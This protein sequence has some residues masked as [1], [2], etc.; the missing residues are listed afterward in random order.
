[1]YHQLAMHVI[2]N[3]AI[4]KWKIPS[5]YQQFFYRT[6]EY[7]AKSYVLASG[8]ATCCN[9]ATVGTISSWETII[10]FNLI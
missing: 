10:K 9:G 7:D 8:T 1:M 5:V 4:S 3:K 6:H 2:K